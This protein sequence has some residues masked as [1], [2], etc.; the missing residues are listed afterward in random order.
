V[1]FAGFDS[2]ELSPLII[3]EYLGTQLLDD[4]KLDV[5]MLKVTNEAVIKRTLYGKRRY[6]LRL[7]GGQNFEL[8]NMRAILE[9]NRSMFSEYCG[10]VMASYTIDGVDSYGEYPT[11]VKRWE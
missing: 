4:F 1:H 3:E 8:A 7:P 10:C 6:V 11:F 9:C 5:P 2:I